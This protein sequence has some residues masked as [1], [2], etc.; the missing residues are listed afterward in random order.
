MVTNA[1]MKAGSGGGNVKAIF[2]LL[3]RL[4]IKGGDTIVSDTAKKMIEAVQ[5][6]P[7]MNE[8]QKAA[9]I[10]EIRKRMSS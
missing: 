3:D 1:K 8:K 5:K 2:D 6:D 7:Y 4:T 10:R 9:R